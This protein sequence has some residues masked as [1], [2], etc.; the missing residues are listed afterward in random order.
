MNNILLVEDDP[1]ITDLLNLHLHTPFY[2]VTAC[3]RA[4]VA[5][6]DKWNSSAYH[7]VILIGYPCCRT[8]ERDRG[9]QTQI[10]AHNGLGHPF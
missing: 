1:Q 10:R 5:L 9:L 3:D 6:R 7:L 2:S 8:C 4:S